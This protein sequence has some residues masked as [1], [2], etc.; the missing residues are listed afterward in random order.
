VW[1]WIHTGD[2]QAKVG[3]EL[4][5]TPQRIGL[6]ADAKECAV[7]IIGRRGVEDR[8]GYEIVGSQSDAAEPLRRCPDEAYN[9]CV[10]TSLPDRLHTHRFVEEDAGENLTWP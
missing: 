1:Q 5:S 3:I 7:P 10:R 9:P 6:Q 8:Q 2:G 4:I